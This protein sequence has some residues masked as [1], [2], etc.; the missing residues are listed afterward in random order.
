MELL[1]AT[2]VIDLQHYN[3]SIIV[4]GETLAAQKFSIIH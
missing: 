3:K 2:Q 4:D 1:L